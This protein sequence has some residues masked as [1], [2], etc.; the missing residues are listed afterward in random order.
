MSMSKKPYYGWYVA[1][2]ISII[3][4]LLEM[5]GGILASSQI[6]VME[7]FHVSR[8]ALSMLL[9]LSALPLSV[10]PIVAGKIVDVMGARKTILIGCALA[11]S[12]MLFLPL[13]ARPWQFSLSFLLVNLGNAAVLFIPV[14]VLVFSWYA[15]RRGMAIGLVMALAAVSGLTGTPLVGFLMERFEWREVAGAAGFAFLILSIPLVLA[16]IKD[17]PNQLNRVSDGD[18]CG[19]EASRDMKVTLRASLRSSTFW[20][21]VAGVSAVRFALS[22]ILAGHTVLD[23]FGRLGHSPAASGAAMDSSSVLVVFGSVLFGL[24]ADQRRPRYAF[25]VCAGLAAFT[26]ALTATASPLWI[27]ILLAIF[28]GFTRGGISVLAPLLTVETFGLSNFG[29]I[30]GLLYTLSWVGMS[31]GNV[32]FSL[33]S[34]ILVDKGMDA[35]VASRVLLMPFGLVALLG[36]WCIFKFHT[37]SLKETT[38]PQSN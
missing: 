29:I 36:G 37:P 25:L 14:Y 35:L 6:R 9:V 17:G 12:G 33:I 23:Y 16:V 24:L 21:L 26:I 28:F 15:E 31:L 20:F 30:Y 18:A 34:G 11:G 1:I 27:L 7:S 13:I 8:S 10:A 5:L 3:I 32:V 4:F 19:M 2:T 22:P 38:G